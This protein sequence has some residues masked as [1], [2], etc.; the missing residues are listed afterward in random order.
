MKAGFGLR[1]FRS[2]EGN[3]NFNETKDFF[4]GRPADGQRRHVVWQS[5]FAIV[6]CRLV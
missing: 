5:I 3:T 1:L 4:L 6:R 2:Q